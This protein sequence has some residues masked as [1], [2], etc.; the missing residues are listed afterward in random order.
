[1]LC[2]ECGISAF[3]RIADT[4]DGWM[5]LVGEVPLDVHLQLVLLNLS[6]KNCS[7]YE[8][9][10]SIR[11]FENYKRRKERITLQIEYLFRRKCSIADRSFGIL[12]GTDNVLNRLAGLH[13]LASLLRAKRHLDMRQSINKK[14]NTK[15][16]IT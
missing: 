11:I 15:Y 14:N 3:D 12:S 4:R 5:D 16:K 8:T 13:L 2:D 6:C 9:K 1:M 10:E 7:I